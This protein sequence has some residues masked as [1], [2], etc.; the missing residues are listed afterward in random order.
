MSNFSLLDSRVWHF[1]LLA[2]ILALLISGKTCADD[3]KEQNP[4]ESATAKRRPSHPHC[5]IYC[6]YTAMK[7]TNREVDFRGLVKPEYIGSRKGSS[8]TELKNAAEDYGIHAVPVGKLTSQVL[9]NCPHPV[10]LH[11]KSDTTSKE[12]DHYELFLGTKNGQARLF[13]PPEPVRLV[14]FRK[15]VPRWDG[16]GLIV[17]ASPIDLFAISAP[18]RKRIIM[19]AVVAIAII[20]AVRW[21]KRWLPKTLLNSRRRLLEL[22]AAQGVVFA[23]TALLCGMIYHFANDEGLLA[24]AT[25]TASIQQA[26]LGNFIPKVSEKKVH[27]LLNTGTVFIDARFA[28]D[29]KAGHLESAINLPVNADDGERQKTTANIAKDARIVLYCQSAGCKFA[30]KVAIKLMLDGFSNVSIF[31]GGW[32]KWVAKSDK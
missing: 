31:K 14:P 29:F 8:L 30:E 17:S 22:S 10:I 18:V 2:C 28:R 23:I 11:V 24:N 4:S 21:A 19:Y 5:G 20:L 13:N 26:H 32:H 12:Y 27:K 6:L 1:L 15:L 7:L 16:N 25:A 9:R 3:E